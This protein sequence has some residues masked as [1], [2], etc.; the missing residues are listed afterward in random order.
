MQSKYLIIQQIFLCPY[1]LPD[2][3]LSSE[4]RSVNQSGKV[5]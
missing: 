5:L 4:N 2:T 1:S 3:T